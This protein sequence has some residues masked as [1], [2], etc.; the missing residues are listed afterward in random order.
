MQEEENA[1]LQTAKRRLQ[2]EVDE[3]TEQTE[4]LTRD[5][6]TAKKSYVV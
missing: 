1:R 2:R 5:L 3:L 6:A 4:T